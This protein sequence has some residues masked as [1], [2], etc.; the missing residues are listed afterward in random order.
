ML[1]QPKS[2]VKYLNES[3]TVR[4]GYETM[5]LYGYTALPV[6]DKNGKYVGSVNE[7]DFL[8]FIL[9]KED[10]IY[11]DVIKKCENKKVKDIIRPKYITPVSVDVDMTTVVNRSLQ[12]NYVPVID[13]SGSFIGIVTRQ[14]IIKTLAKFPPEVI[15]G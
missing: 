1:L 12:Q 2:E 8:W 6:I 13:D 10:N 15:N 9:E 5:K 4:Q 3:Q 11:S 14:N 7:G